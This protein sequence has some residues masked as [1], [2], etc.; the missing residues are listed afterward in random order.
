MR[1]LNLALLTAVLLPGI[2]ARAATLALPSVVFT[3]PS[4]TSITCTETAASNL[5]VPVASGTVIFTCTVA[6]S[7]WAGTV[8]LSGGS[9]FT[10][11]GLSGNTFNV[12][13]STAVTTPAT[14]SPGTLTTSP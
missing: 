3:S 7:N 6:P 14:N 12:S 10:I 9:P 8:S 11:S 4:S 2:A 13:L 1:R 5:V